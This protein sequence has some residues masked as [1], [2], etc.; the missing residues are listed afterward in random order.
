VF[1]S[2]QVRLSSTGSAVREPQGS[3]P[4]DSADYFAAT[5]EDEDVESY[6]KLTGASLLSA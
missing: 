1:A 2:K 3:D 6:R 4:L 5:K